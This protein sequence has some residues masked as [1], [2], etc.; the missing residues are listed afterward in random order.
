MADVRP[1]FTI[2]ENP[3]TQAGSPQHLVSEGQAVA[4][5][6]YGLGIVAKDSSGNAIFLRTNAAG[7]LLVNAEAADVVLLGGQGDNAGSATVVTLFDIALQND[8]E[9]KNLEW[10]CSCF[11]EATFELVHVD[12]LGGGGETFNILG[13]VKVGAGDYTD[14]G[15]VASPFTAGSTGTQVLRV[16]AL[17]L[18]ATSQLEASASIEEIQVV[19]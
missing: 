4:A 12:D 7:Q 3:A 2:L 5:K 16:R 15:K 17:N 6:N 13:T 11:R 8:Y 1:V 18:N 10:V 9:Y 14:S 19:P